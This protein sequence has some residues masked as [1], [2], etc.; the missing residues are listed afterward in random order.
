MALSSAAQLICA[1][2]LRLRTHAG[3]TVDRLNVTEIDTSVL[4]ELPAVRRATADGTS[5]DQAIVAVVVRLVEGLEV[6][7]RLIADAALSLGVVRRTIGE[8]PALT[9]LYADDLGIRR[10]ALVDHWETLHRLLGVTPPPREISVRSLRATAEAKTFGVLATRCVQ[11]SSE[12]LQTS[13]PV[14]A[15]KPTRQGAKS[16]AIIGGAVMDHIFLVDGI[17]ALNTSA[18]AIARDEHPGGKGLNLAVGLARMELDPQLI[19]TIGDDAN[20]Q[21]VLD[22]M[23]AEGLRTNFI[24][25][26]T[27]ARTPITTVHVTEAGD[28]SAVGWKNLPTIRRNQAEFRA[29]TSTIKAADAVFV[30][31]EPS[32]DEVRWALS[33]ASKRASDRVLLVQPSPPMDSARRL[34]GHLSSVDYLVGSEWELRCL[35]APEERDLE[36]DEVVRRLLNLGVKTICAV[37]QLRCRIRTMGLTADVH[38]PDVPVNENPGAREAFSAALIYQIL[39][40]GRELNVDTIRWAAAAMA[41]NISLEEIPEGMP[42]P[43]EVNEILATNQIME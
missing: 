21:R 13:P 6:T 43:D 31:F 15:P 25:R 8:H 4:G 17:P 40:I 33:A 37:E 23:T 5:V 27:D 7:D 12:V 30:T 24:K 10:Q 3:L 29:L 32:A 35:L 18:N 28:S 22:Y 9:K 41:A 2:L 42:E 26:V 19:T 11:P 1:V 20:G 34:Y 38:A 36:F 14:D 16:V 39:K